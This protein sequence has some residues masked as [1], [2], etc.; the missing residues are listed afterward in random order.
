M[1]LQDILQC[2]IKLYKL[3]FLKKD[4]PT[5]TYVNKCLTDESKIKSSGIHPIEVFIQMK[6]FEKGGK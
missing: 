4:T 3:G 5:Q 2:L 1:T 6:N